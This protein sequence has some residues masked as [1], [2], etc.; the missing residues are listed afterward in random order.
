MAKAAGFADPRILSVGPIAVN[1]PAMRDL[2]GPTKFYSITARLFKLPGLLESACEDY[3]QV[4]IYKV[5]PHRRSS[6]LE[7]FLKRME[8]IILVFKTGRGGWIELLT[9]LFVSCRKWLG[10]ACTDVEEGTCMKAF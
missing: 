10:L 2:L 6:Q 1:D 8:D 5:S 3:G 9:F 4:A 7:L